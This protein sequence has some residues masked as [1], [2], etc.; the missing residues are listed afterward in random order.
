MSKIGSPSNPVGQI[1]VK[2]EAIIYKL[3]VDGSLG[4]VRGST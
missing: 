1:F 4:T 3:S 2:T